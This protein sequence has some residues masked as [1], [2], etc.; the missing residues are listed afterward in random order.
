[1]DELVESFQAQ[2]QRKKKTNRARRTKLLPYD[3]K[4]SELL[5]DRYKIPKN[6]RL[7]FESAK[8]VEKPA[9]FSRLLES[10][11]TSLFG[12]DRHVKIRHLFSRASFG[13]SVSEMQNLSSQSTDDLVDQLVQERSKPEPPGE[14]V[15]EPFDINEYLSWTPEEQM[16]FLE[17]NRERI[18]ELR[19]WWLEL[20][21]DKPFNLLEKMTFFWHGHFTTDIES[22]ILATFLFKQNDTI[23]TYAL[24]NFRDFLKAIYKDP[25]ML[26]YL[27]GNENVASA[28]NEN[29]ARELL[30]LFTLGVGNY[31]EPDI[32]AAARALTGWNIDPFNITSF[33]NPN[34]HDYAIKNFLGESGNFNGDDIV[35]IILQQDQAARFICK[36]FYNFFVSR[37]ENE[38]FVEQLANEFRNQ[39]YE[40]EPVIRML[41]KSTE[42]YS[43]NASASLIKSPVDLTVANARMLSS[44]SVNAFFVLVFQSLIDQEIMNPPNV[45]GWPGQRAWISPTTYV[46]R[47]TISEIYVNPEFLR[48]QN[49]GETPVEFDVIAF[50]QSFGISNARD[51]AH[52]ITDHLLRIP[53]QESTFEFLLSVLVGSAGEDDWSLQYSGV[54]RLLTE[55]LTQVVRLPEFHLG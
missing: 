52:A 3:P 51:L 23:R 38:A 54:D 35:D 9:D 36:K 15:T 12:S 1:M 11:N 16:A 46:F 42:F 43:E 21:M 2:R 34:N 24:G 14:W 7:K 55:F 41:L 18:E 39:N 17:L 22:A 10:K 45:A 13:L 49:T 5:P 28:P 47:N 44:Q 33:F 27:N 31:T 32:K 40:I 25:A 30:E 6:W 19:S 4:L 26:L 8:N 53:I 37:E 50:A 48:D 20:M 29:F